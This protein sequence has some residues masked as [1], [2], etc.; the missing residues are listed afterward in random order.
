MEEPPGDQDKHDCRSGPLGCVLDDSL[1]NVTVY[2]VSCQEG[3][4][5][6]PAFA[7]S[8]EPPGHSLDGDSDQ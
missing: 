5:S 6:A 7:A 4:S 1:S 8:I 2:G 3:F